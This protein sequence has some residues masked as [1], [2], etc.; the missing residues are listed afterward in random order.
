ME[1]KPM[2]RA[3]LAYTP[4]SIG[5]PCRR[6]RLFIHAEEENCVMVFRGNSIV[7]ITMPPVLPDLQAASSGFCRLFCWI[8]KPLHP[9]SAACSAGF[10]IR[11]DWVYAFVMRILAYGIANPHTQCGHIANPPERKYKR[12]GEAFC[13][14]RGGE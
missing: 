8:D 13:P 14:A 11:Q 2:L 10:V 3:V 5:K 9:E 6:H 4:R 12:L 7:H 1:F